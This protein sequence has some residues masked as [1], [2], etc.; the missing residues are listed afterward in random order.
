MPITD[1]PIS[2]KKKCTECG[3]PAVLRWENPLTGKKIY[4]CEVCLENMVQ[5]EE[6]LL[7]EDEDN[8]DGD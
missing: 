5:H 8:E 6:S 1:N 4:V 3:N 7:N 2:I